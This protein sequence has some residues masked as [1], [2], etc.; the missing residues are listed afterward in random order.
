MGL[1]LIVVLSADNQ[2]I[3]ITDT[4]RG[5]PAM[6][7]TDGFYFCKVCLIGDETCVERRSCLD[8]CSKYF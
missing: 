8:V 2:K 7:G 6:V 1:Y 4:F 3:I 5:T